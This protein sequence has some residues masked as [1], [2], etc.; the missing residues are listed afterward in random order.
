MCNL[1]ATDINV[2]FQ[3]KLY[4]YFWKK[5]AQENSTVGRFTLSAY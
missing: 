2:I 1:S 3:V 5:L 4:L